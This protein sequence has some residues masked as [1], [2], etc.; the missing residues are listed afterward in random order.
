[1]YLEIFIFTLVLFVLVTSP[2]IVLYDS[3]ISEFLDSGYLF[4]IFCETLQQNGLKHTPIYDKKN[5]ERFWYPNKKLL[6][7]LNVSIPNHRVKYFTYKMF[8][9]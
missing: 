5:Q 4:I 8:F 9:W 6:L 3:M 1:M 7:F 2:R